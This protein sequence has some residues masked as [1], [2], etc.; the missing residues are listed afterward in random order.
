MSRAKKRHFQRTIQDGA[1]SDHAYDRLSSNLD[2][3]AWQATYN[4]EGI[5]TDVLLILDR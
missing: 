1:K 5:G 4:G 2:I 3:S